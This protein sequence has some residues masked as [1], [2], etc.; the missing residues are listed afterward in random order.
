VSK[1]RRWPKAIQCAE[2]LLAQDSLREESHRLVI[3]LCQASGDRARAVRAY[4][5]CAAT[6]QRELGIDPSPESRAV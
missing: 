4:H 3:R 1:N 2:R 5:A 6:L